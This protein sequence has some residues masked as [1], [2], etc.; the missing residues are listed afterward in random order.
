MKF[1]VLHE[2]KVKPNLLGDY[3]A[4]LSRTFQETCKFPGF[5]SKEVFANLDDP[6]NLVIQV[7]WDSRQDFQRHSAYRDSQ[8]D[9]EVFIPMLSEEASLRFFECADM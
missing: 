6:C 4:Y 9:K 3:K 8:G 2:M 5:Q 1:V 7:C